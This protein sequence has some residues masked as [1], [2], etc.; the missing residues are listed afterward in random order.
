LESGGP[1]AAAPTREGFGS[2]LV[3]SG[4]RHH[5]GSVDY[6]FEPSG[7]RC[8]FW[9]IMP[10]EGKREGRTEAVEPAK[11]PHAWAK[12]VISSPETKLP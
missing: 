6:A 5:Q 4:V 1:P 3:R 12:M 9:L 7:L 10:A 2:K 8:R 11:Q